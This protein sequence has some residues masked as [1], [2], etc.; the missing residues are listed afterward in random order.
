MKKELLSKKKLE[1][2]DLENSQ[3]DYNAK[4][5]EAC[6]EENT[7]VFLLNNGGLKKVCFF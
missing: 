1:P 5:E 4:I 6:S 7:K 3:L 2:K